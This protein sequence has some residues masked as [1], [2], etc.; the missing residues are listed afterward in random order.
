MGFFVTF[1]GGGVIAFALCSLWADSIVPLRS[2]VVLVDRNTGKC[3]AL[4]I[5]GGNIASKEIACPKGAK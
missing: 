1:C 5:E 2:E 4:R 3:Y